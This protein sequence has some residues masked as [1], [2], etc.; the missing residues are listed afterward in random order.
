ME[1]KVK[2]KVEVN[3]G[4]RNDKAGR[5]YFGVKVAAEIKLVGL[6]K[7]KVKVEVN[8]GVTVDMNWLD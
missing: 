3:L 1:V 2:I 4:V 6:V 5:H 7:V 8:V